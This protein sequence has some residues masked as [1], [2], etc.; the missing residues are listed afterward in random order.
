MVATVEVVIY[1]TTGWAVVEKKSKEHDR[2]TIHVVLVEGWQS[3]L[4]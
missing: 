4:V 1:M 3:T 2:D